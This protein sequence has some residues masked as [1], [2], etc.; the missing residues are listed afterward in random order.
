M[1]TAGL[2][3]SKMVS[4]V[5]SGRDATGGFIRNG[6]MI[7]ASSI[8]S[9]RPSEYHK[10]LTPLTQDLLPIIL[11]WAGVIIRLPTLNKF[12][13]SCVA[14]ALQQPQIFYLLNNL[15]LKIRPLTLEPS[16][17]GRIL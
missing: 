12:D 6:Y 10:C 9:S 3:Y 5:L 2:E 17:S 4:D 15:L 16:R 11:P 14:L 13:S 7:F 8:L 1:M